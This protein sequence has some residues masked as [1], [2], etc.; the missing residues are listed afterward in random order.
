MTEDLKTEISIRKHND[1]QNIGTLIHRSQKDQVENHPPETMWSPCSDLTTVGTMDDP[2]YFTT[3]PLGG[4]KFRDELDGDIGFR[5][6]NVGTYYL[7]R[8]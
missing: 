8:I 3:N 6:W 2:A 4:A 7:I 5:E 1:I